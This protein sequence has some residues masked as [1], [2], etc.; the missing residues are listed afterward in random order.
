MPR[1]GDAAQHWWQQQHWLQQR[2]RLRQ[3]ACRLQRV[4]HW[5]LAA[6]LPMSCVFCGAETPPPAR[7]LCSRCRT[8]LAACQPARTCPRCA[9]PLPVVSNGMQAD[10]GSQP[11]CV[12]CRKQPLRFAR[13]FALGAYRGVLKE[14]VILAKQPSRRVVAKTL[15]ALL[16]QHHGAA[17]GQLGIDCVC[18]VPSHWRRRLKRRGTPSQVIAETLGRSLAVATRPLL[19]RIRHTRKQG[20][21][22][23]AQRRENVDGSFAV[24]TGYV[25][26]LT[27]FSPRGK[28]VLLV[29][30]VLTTGATANAAAGA[31]RQA[32]A[33]EVTMVVLAR[34]TGSRSPA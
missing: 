11:R 31:L 2:D 21:L 24:N 34:A 19:R 4:G 8:R 30:D 13:T 14:A 1:G 27:G 15:A 17:L 6:I 5:T 18:P 26:S 10:D 9:M 7:A 12:H 32:G 20:M 22:S 16:A 28:H 25:F 29:D 23:P 3:A 33:T